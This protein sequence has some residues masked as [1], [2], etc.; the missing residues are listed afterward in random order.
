MIKGGKKT[1]QVNLGSILRSLT[2]S[3][4]FKAVLGGKIKVKSMKGEIEVVL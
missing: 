4:V 3:F 2:I 1:R